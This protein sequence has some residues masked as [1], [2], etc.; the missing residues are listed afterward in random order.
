M[1]IAIAVSR[2]MYSSIPVTVHHCAAVGAVVVFCK[3]IITATVGADII[4][5]VAKYLVLAI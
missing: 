4:I 5:C 3:C 2:F 1:I